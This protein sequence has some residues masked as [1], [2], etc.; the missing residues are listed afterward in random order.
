[1]GHKNTLLL[2]TEVM[3]MCGDHLR[4]E[5]NC[6]IDLRANAIFIVGTHGTCETVFRYTSTTEWCVN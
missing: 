2:I 6:T 3:I 1:M 5:Y 4:E